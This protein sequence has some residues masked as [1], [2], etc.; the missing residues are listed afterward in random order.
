MIMKSFFTIPVLL[1]LSFI[2]IGQNNYWS[3]VTSGTNKNLLS[4]SFGSSL[5]GYISGS[6][7]LLLKTTDGGNSWVKLN[8]TGLQFNLAARDIIHLNFINSST[9]YAIVSNFKIPDY[10]GQLY[11]TINGG[12]TWTAV[13]SGN[14]ASYSTFFYDENNGYQVGS[15]FFAGLTLEKMTAGV[16]GADKNFGWDASH[17]LY[18]IDCRNNN[19]CITGGSG[20][21]VYRTFNGGA[22]WDTVIT[23]TDS[24]IRSIKFIND[25]YIIAA[26]DNPMGGI[27]ISND[28]GRT[29]QNDMNTLTFYYPQLKSIVRSVKDSFIA[30][31]KVS[32][33]SPNA[34]VILC[35][36]SSFPSNFGTE[37]PLNAVAMSNDSIAY[38]VGDSGL[39]LSNRHKLL[40][41]NEQASQ[42]PGITLY[43]NPSK[44]QFMINAETMFSI[45]VYDV[46]GKLIQQDDE[47]S[48]EHT[49]SLSGHI[50]GIYLVKVRT[51]AGEEYYRKLMLE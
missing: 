9:G 32:F 18:T 16:W 21:N 51:I 28:T 31:G 1:L 10:L 5:V 22:S 30:V 49:I 19:T 41:I 15:A 38:A 39:I 44:G 46:V 40:D 33:S 35:G 6:D 4:V 26:T 12:A 23:S 43:P 8:Y 48:K 24:A 17:F 20:G 25:S 14:I 47:L 42:E 7:S 11:K 34:G 50:S 2:A 29:W 27:I 13:T 45:S 37:Q 3:K 36:G